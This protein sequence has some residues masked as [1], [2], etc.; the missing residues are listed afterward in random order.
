MDLSSTG[1]VIQGAT[2]AVTA[3]ATVSNL[4]SS[5]LSQSSP[6]SA[7]SSINQIQLLLLLLL[8]RAYL[9]DMIVLYL[10]SISSSLLSFD[11]DLEN[12]YGF[13]LIY[14]YFEVEQ[15]DERM[16]LLHLE[17]GSSIINILETIIIILGVS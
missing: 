1:Q 2:G 8:L 12:V 11:F 6:Q 7:F 10:R 3:G 15:P 17:S 9:P 16:A 14:D 4:M 13:S 5:L